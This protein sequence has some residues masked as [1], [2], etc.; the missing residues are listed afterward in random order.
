MNE[1]GKSTLLNKTGRLVGFG[2]DKHP[3]KPGW[4]VNFVFYW[5]KPDEWVLCLG[6]FR[7][8]PE[9]EAMRPHLGEMV[10]GREFA[11]YAT[12]GLQGMDY[13]TFKA[14]LNESYPH[15]KFEWWTENG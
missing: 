7:G 10:S 8:K 5:I 13:V 2:Y 11:P 15:V 6:E 9:P 1:T 14:F 3:T 12:R 4:G